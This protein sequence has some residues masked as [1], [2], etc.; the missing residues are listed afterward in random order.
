MKIVTK[1]VGGWLVE[2]IKNEIDELIRAG[3][4]NID[5]VHLLA[6]KCRDCLYV[7]FATLR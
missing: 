3:M 6:A 4:R 5:A 7:F 1:L 2:F